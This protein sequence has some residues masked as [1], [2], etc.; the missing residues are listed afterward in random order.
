MVAFE[1]KNLPALEVVPGGKVCRKGDFHP[2][3]LLRPE[4]AAIETQ[5]FVIVSRITLGSAHQNTR[6][7][8]QNYDQEQIGNHFQENA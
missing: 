4:Q 3:S 5:Q 2:A 1:W 8:D 6:R 7:Y